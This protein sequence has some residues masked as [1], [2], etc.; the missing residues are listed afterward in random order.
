LIT[1]LSQLFCQQ[2]PL[3]VVFFYQRI[4]LGRQA[5]KE[6]RVFIMVH[7]AV[8]AK[9]MLHLAGL[10]RSRPGF[11]AA[12]QVIAVVREVAAVG[13]FAVGQA[14]HPFGVGS[15]QNSVV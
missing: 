7:R 13:Q 2:V 4:D 14:F 12:G 8:L 5:F 1:Q 6:R 15:Q 3:L 9:R 11:D 10:G